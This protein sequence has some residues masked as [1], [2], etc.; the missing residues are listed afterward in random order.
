[1]HLYMYIRTYEGTC[2]DIYLFFVSMI[3]GT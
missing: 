2:M 1:M 3:I